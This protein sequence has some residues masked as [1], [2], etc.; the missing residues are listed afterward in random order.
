[1]DAGGEYGVWAD[2][3]EGVV[4]GGGELG[5]CLGEAYWLT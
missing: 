3:D 4:S 2:F 5:G 1:M